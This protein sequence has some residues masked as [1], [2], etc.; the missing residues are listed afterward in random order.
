MKIVGFNTNEG[1]RHGVAEGDVM[2]DLQPVDKNVPNDL[3]EWVRRDNGDLAAIKAL[4]ERAPPEFA[5][6]VPSRTRLRRC[7]QHGR[8]RRGIHELS[9]ES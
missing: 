3:G 4:A 1:L 2:I 6:P 8:E 9:K 7:M 5:P